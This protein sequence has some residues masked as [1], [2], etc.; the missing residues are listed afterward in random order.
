MERN[1]WVTSS[2]LGP[3]ILLSTRFSD[4]SKV[5]DQVP[6][7]YTRSKI[8]VAR[9]AIFIFLGNKTLDRKAARM[10]WI[11]S[12]L[13]SS[14]EHFWFVSVV[15]KYLRCV[16]RSR[17]M[18]GS[19]RRAIPHVRCPLTQSQ[20]KTQ[21]AISTSR[22]TASPTQPHPPAARLL[23]KVPYLEETHWIRKLLQNSYCRR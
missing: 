7:P 1:N 18:P 22:P 8:T 2:L 3:D 5:T 12:A 14:C 20:H 6:H 16:L 13:I 4:M 15:A 23:P 17:S 21:V 10:P 19:W 11:E 9:T